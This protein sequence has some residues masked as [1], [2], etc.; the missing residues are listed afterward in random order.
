MRTHPHPRRAA[1]AAGPVVAVLVLGSACGA[2]S[3]AADAGP[4]PL[5]DETY[6]RVLEQGV[7]PALVYTVRLPGFELAEQ[8]AGVL[9]ES[10][11]G[12]TYLPSDPPYTAEVS[13]EVRAGEYDDARC[14]RDPLRGP[15]GAAPVAVESCEPEADGW[16]RTGGD[17]HEY[18]A[19]R[20][21]HHLVLSGPAEAVDREALKTAALDAR[22]QEGAGLSP[23]QP[24]SPPTR[25]DL[26]TTGDGAPVDPHG[27]SRPGG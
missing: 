26:P 15:T 17:R 23:T 14:E 10:D 12:A 8:S 27:T 1:R 20:T 19:A 18:V 13:L 4:A 3:G 21:G 22:P 24:S 2:D 7:D 5:S 11:Y 16:Y 25:G 6:Q 9:G